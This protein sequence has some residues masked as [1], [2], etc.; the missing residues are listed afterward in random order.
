MRRVA[1]SIRSK[2]LSAFLHAVK[3]PQS[4][5]PQGA[6][7]DGEYATW[8]EV[9]GAALCHVTGPMTTRRVGGSKIAMVNYRTTPI[10]HN[11]A[12]QQKACLLWE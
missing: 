2:T 8:V 5:A 6:Q 12:L 9:E 11:I 7:R 10:A 1:N 3:L 4:V